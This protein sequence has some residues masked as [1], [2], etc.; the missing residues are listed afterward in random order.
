M[1]HPKYFLEGS[2]FSFTDLSGDLVIVSCFGE[3]FTCYQ[4]IKDGRY[5]AAVQLMGT[6]SE[7]SKYKCEFTLRAA[8]GVEQISKTFLVRGYLEDWETIFNSAICLCLD[9]KTFSCRK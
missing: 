9:E 4:N 2:A 6:N 1:A 5:Y 3:L 7:A 8:N